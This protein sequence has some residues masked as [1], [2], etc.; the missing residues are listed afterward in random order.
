MGYNTRYQLT[1]PREATQVVQLL[2]F[3]DV[4]GKSFT[5]LRK[6]VPNVEQYFL[7][8]EDLMTKLDRAANKVR[9]KVKN[10]LSDVADAEGIVRI[11]YE[12]WTNQLD[13][14]KWYEHET[15]LRLFSSLFPDVL[16]TLRG[17][18]EESEDIWVK[19]FKGGKVQVAKA[20]ISFEPFD[21]KLLK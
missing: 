12:A 13:E 2:E 14:C 21:P 6:R 15:D 20:H 7:E 5:E 4:K 9:A 18:G 10:T 19:Y 16:L 8:M 1:I 3:P 11:I 17:D